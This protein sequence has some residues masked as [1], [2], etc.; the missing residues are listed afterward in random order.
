MAAASRYRKFLKLC[1]MWP[2]D[3][4]KT[5]RDLGL[6][7]RRRIAEGFR[8]GD[9]SEIDVIE[10]DR[11]YNSLYRIAS[12]HFRRSYPRLR[13]SSFSGL[14]L[15]DCNVMNSTEGLKAMKSTNFGFMRIFSVFQRSW[16]RKCSLVHNSFWLCY[17]CVPLIICIE[18][19]WLICCVAIVVY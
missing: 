11:I 5:D 7:I 10:C 8:H 18:F 1:E 4:S 17:D 12:N 16:Q 14:S 6:Y 19:V 13:D 15:Q 2:V 9:A 3:A